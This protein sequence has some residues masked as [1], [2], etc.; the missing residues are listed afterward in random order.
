MVVKIWRTHTHIHAHVRGRWTCIR[1]YIHNIHKLF[2]L[3]VSI[4]VEAILTDEHNA[5]VAL[6]ARK[7]RML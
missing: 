4:L 7:L 2:G 1:I 6:A 5:N 3:L